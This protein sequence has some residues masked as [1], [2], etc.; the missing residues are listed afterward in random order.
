MDP[1]A[2]K[3][4]NFASQE[5]FWQ[6]VDRLV[7]N[8]SVVVDRPKGSRHPRYPEVMYPLDYG[9]LE[10]TTSMDG[11]G[12]D[13][14]IG[15]QG[16]RPPG[17]VALTIDLKKK[18]LEIKLILGCSPEETQTILQFSNDANAR[19][20]LIER[21][22]DGFDWLRNR[23]SIRRFT[24][25]PVSDEIIRR[26][27]EAAT[28]APSSHNRQPWRMAVVISQESK[29]TLAQAMGEDF[30]A[31]L[32]RDGLMPDEIWAQVKRS[33]DRI[34]QA[35]VCLVLCLDP[36]HGDRYPD[37]KRIQAEQVMGIQS[38]AMAG[39]NLMLA[40]DRLGLGSVWM[41]APLFAPDAVQKALDLPA[42][43]LPQGMILLGYPAKEPVDRPRYSVEDIAKFY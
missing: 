5:Q 32:T 17:A 16:I 1:D 40:A 31:D 9:Y 18:D 39:Q 2:Q 29:T 21:E 30:Q 6:Y 13:V 22:P 42:T 38:V 11:G 26:I 34:T 41:C 8:H 14:W 24:D 12:I 28:W 25:Q 4:E 15:S 23:R 33:N 37:S 19:A 20:M 10:D 3:L 7:S 27:L 36:T 43:W 35:P